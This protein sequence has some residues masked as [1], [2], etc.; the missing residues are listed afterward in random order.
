MALTPTYDSILSRVQLTCTLL[1][2]DCTWALVQRSTDGTTWTTVRGAAEWDVTAESFTTT[3]DDYEF[4]ADVLTTYRA[5]PYDVTNFPQ[6]T[7]LS[8]LVQDGTSGDYASTPDAASLDIVGDL[9]LRAEISARDWTPSA[10][11]A[12]IGKYTPTGNQRSYY[13]YL[14]TTGVVG[15]RWSTDGTAVTTKTSTVA[16]T[17][18]ASGRIAIKATLD[19]DNGAAG[20]DV[21]FYTASAIDG[22][23]T[24]LG[25]TVTT[26]GVTSIFSSTAV[27]RAGAIDASGSTSVF[28]GIIHAAR[29]YSGIAGTQV[30]N[31]NFEIQANNATSFA[32][33]ATPAKT[34]TVNGAAEIVVT[35]TNTITPDLTEVWLKS[36]VRPYLN[37]A[38][39]V[40]GVSEI[41]RA[42]RNG[43]FNIIGRSY[44]IA[45]TDL[46][47]SRQLN[48]TIRTSTR[49]ASEELDLVLASGDPVF[50]HSPPNTDHLWLPSAFYA[51]IGDTSQ[52]RLGIKTE[53]LSDFTL[54]LTE[55]AAPDPDIVGITTSWASIVAGYATWADVIAAFADWAAVLESIGSEEDVI[56]P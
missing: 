24:Q 41:T 36:I 42:A 51:V 32:D 4:P 19:V 8:G 7:Q 23:Y 52:A 10:N 53:T 50:L 40:V 56:V 2:S 30:A 6:D 55:T 26:G 43:V 20:N 46:R 45:V 14:D 49:A 12:L 1:G 15:L 28:T 29:I 34:W 11:Q 21:K 5:R 44:P 27:A 54:P 17:I 25:T 22:T 48:V 16:P 39:R 33:T 37:R 47:S 13:M 35:Q 9:E 3:L 31:P 18:P 38:V